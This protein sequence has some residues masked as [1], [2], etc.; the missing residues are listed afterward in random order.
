M[1]DRVER[2]KKNIIWTFV[3]KIVNLLFPFITQTCLIYILGVQYIGLDGL[4]KSVLMILSLTELGIGSALVFSMYKPIADGDDE[5]VCALLAFYKK[6]YHAI[7]S[8]ILVLGLA[9]LPFIQ[10]LI[11]GEVPD[12]INIYVLYSVYLLNTVLSYYLFAYKT[13]L[14]NACQMVD[15]I[16]RVDI[17]ANSAKCILQCVGLLL[18]PSYYMFVWVIPLSTVLRNLFVEY[19]SRKKYPQYVCRGK[20]PAEDIHVI[21]D[22]VKGLFF[23]SIGNVVLFGVD[24]IVISAFLGLSLLGKYNNYLY[25]HNALVNLVGVISASIIPVVGNSIAMEDKEKNYRNFRQFNL[26]WLCLISWCAIC[27]MCL[28]QPFVKVWAGENFLFSKKIAFLFVLYFYT[29]K[30]GDIIWVYKS[31]GGIWKEGRYIRLLGATVNLCLNI[32]WVSRIGIAG[33][34][35]STVISLVVIIDP[36]GGKVLFDVYFDYKHAWLEYIGTLLMHFLI[37]VLIGGITYGMCAH[38]SESGIVGLVLRT[39]ICV[40]V[41]I[42]LLFL[43]Y[44]RDTRLKQTGALVKRLIKAQER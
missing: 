24:N 29:N 31:A 32:F 43:I 27:Q 28:L 40:P 39:L 37:T 41:P 33:V 16:S 5:K 4:F 35:L 9:L 12:D 10:N 3:G 15:M 6:C 36:F 19:V 38:I 44:C 1:S 14:L 23:Q 34:L 26:L 25:I 13:S 11:S 18:L 30:M 22:K 20:L 17:V 42:I 2:S 8:V 21:K 7:G